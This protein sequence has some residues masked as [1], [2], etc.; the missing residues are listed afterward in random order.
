MWMNHALR[1]F[2]L[3]AQRDRAARSDFRRWE[4]AYE[5]SDD[6]W[7]DVPS[8]SRLRASLAM[9]LVALSRLTRSVS[10]RACTLATRIEGH[11]A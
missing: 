2:E 5:R 4:R 9:P 10:E 1:A 3:D 11:P 8:A 6:A 7:T